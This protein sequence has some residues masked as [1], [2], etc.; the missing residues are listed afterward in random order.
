MTI[1]CYAGLYDGEWQGRV[2]DACLDKHFI[3]ATKN[4][5]VKGSRAKSALASMEAEFLKLHHS[6]DK[7]DLIIA[8][9]EFMKSKLEEGGFAGKV[10]A[11][12]NFLTDSQME[13]ARKVSNTH[14]FEDAVD[15]NDHTS[16]SS[17]D[18]PKKKE[19]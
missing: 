5:C 9:S 6:Y 8:P 7:I 15:G 1:F 19:S 10:V 13:M 4:V 12:Q 18:F 2:C 17:G 14:K 16:C 3:H 11:L